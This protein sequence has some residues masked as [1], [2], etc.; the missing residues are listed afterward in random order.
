MTQQ[1]ELCLP[2]LLSRISTAQDAEL[3]PIMEAISNRLRTLHPDWEILYFALP[4]TDQEQALLAL[5][6][7]VRKYR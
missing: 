7:Q 5:I 2:D 3:D 1:N 4:K 6:E